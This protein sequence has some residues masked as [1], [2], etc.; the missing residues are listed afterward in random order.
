MEDIDDQPPSEKEKILIIRLSSIGDIV[1]TTPIIRALYNKFPDKEIHFLLKE[2]FKDVLSNNPYITKIHYYQGKQLTIDALRKEN[3]SFVVDLQKNH[4]SHQL[5]RNLHLPYGTFPKCNV[6]KTL[7]VRLKWNVLPNIHIVDRYFKAVESLDVPNDNLGLD[8]F[9]SPQDEVDSGDFPAVF[10][11]GFVAVVIGGAYFTKRIPIEKV[12]EICKLIYK[13]VM[14]L[15]GKDV[16]MVGEEIKSQLGNRAYNACGKYNLRQS[17]SIIK[18]SLCL[19]T[20]D[21]GLMHIAAGLNVPTA[22]LWG[23]TVPEFGMYPYMPNHRENFR[24]FEVSPLA[25]RPCSKL[26][27]KKCPKGHFK[28]MQQIDSN[29]VADWINDFE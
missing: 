9:I 5:V 7:L 27:F 28:C 22:T 13:P 24:I 29:E 2:N 15:G 26:G 10:E 1:L 14:L 17:A 4:R 20:P 8:F 16:E 21:T 6:A 19:I 23:N 11:D 12:V 25:C 18:K 3:F